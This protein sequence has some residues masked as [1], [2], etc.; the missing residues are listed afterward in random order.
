MAPSDGR[1][2]SLAAMKLAH[3]QLLRSVGTTRISSPEALAPVIEFLKSGVETGAALDTPG[4][5][6]QAQGLLDYWATVIETT[7]RKLKQNR[8]SGPDVAG[9]SAAIQGAPVAEASTQAAVPRIRYED[10]LLKEFDDESAHSE[11]LR[12]DLWYES[13]SPGDQALARRILLRFTTLS[14]TGR[15]WQ[16]R[17]APR[18]ELLGLG[19]A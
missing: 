10:T 12:A 11:A 7:A 13:L 15:T 19:P 8:P 16:L 4:D 1:F 6:I 2:G 9:E 17:S 14:P 3:T 5:R 18:T